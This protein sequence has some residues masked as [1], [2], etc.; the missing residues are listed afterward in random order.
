[1]SDNGASFVVQDQSAA[2][3]LLSD[4][5]IHDGETPE[6]V[7]THGAILFL[8]PNRAYKMKRAVC[9]S[10]MDFSTRALRLAALQE[11]L[12]V[13]RRTAPRLYLG[14]APIAATAGGLRLGAVGE[15]AADAIDHVLVM[16]RF[17]ATFDD[18]AKQDGIK[19][20][21]IAAI[22]TQIAAFH[23]I[24]EI[25]HHPAPAQRVRAVAVTAFEQARLY[26]DILPALVV[27]DV[28][29]QLF[30]RTTTA[31]HHLTNRAAAGLQRHCHDDLHLRN[32]CLFEGHPNLFD[33]IE[34]N[35]DFAESD[36]LYDLAFLLMDLEGRNLRRF[37]NTAL[38]TYLDCR[39][40]DGWPDE[41]GLRLLPLFLCMRAAIHG[42]I[43]AH[44]A[45]AAT[46]IIAA[47]LREEAKAR[48]AEASGY[49]Q[50]AP[51]RLI[52]V[53]GLSG[54]GKSALS[55]LIAPMTGSAPGARWLRSDVL[56]KALAGLEPLEHLPPEAYSQ[57]RSAEVYRFMLE[58]AG[59]AL[60]AGHSVVLDAVFARPAERFA[61]QALAARLGVPFIGLWV[62]APMATRIHRA[63]SRTG[64]A[65]DAGVDVVREQTAYDL[66]PLTWTRV[67]NN[68]TLSTL[69]A[70]AAAILRRAASR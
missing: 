68:G 16:Q 49:F 26:P 38:N 20:E 23:R 24:A 51:S 6:R 69:E 37:A 65:S 58:T 61:A 67:E 7:D 39:I 41:T 63:A 55:G 47:D 59:H 25:I 5:T 64:D 36:V 34:F 8:T 53:G 40:K 32:V 27:A 31:L 15:E 52:A 11:E 28:E 14:I 54:T 29:R 57:A 2:L 33:A 9:F 60:A 17:E 35:T 4:P 22:A 46:D 21:H 3:R 18:L 10:F 62:E 44:R 48:L 45:A 12:R 43:C 70:K 30:E 42:A 1:M 56:R 50:P 13:N 19:L 66:S